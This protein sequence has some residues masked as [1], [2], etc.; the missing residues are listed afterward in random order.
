MSLKPWNHK[1]NT[2]PRSAEAQCL[3][4]GLQPVIVPVLTFIDW[5]RKCQGAY[6]DDPYTNR[7]QGRLQGMGPQ[8]PDLPCAN[9]SIGEEVELGWRGLLKSS[10]RWKPA[11]WSRG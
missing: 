1:S 3:S 5:R 2:P 10:K 7:N 8:R 9:V 4:L 11:R 6:N